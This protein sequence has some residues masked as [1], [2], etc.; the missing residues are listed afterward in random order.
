[1]TN[2]M[3]LAGDQPSSWPPKKT[4]QQL[5]IDHL[6][7][8]LDYLASQGSNCL[9]SKKYAENWRENIESLQECLYLARFQLPG[10]DI[11][12]SPNGEI[13]VRRTL[14]STN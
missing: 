2:F 5:V 14:S 4:T 10:L 8:E 12:F 6:E 7:K 9:H 13:S 1:M 11:S 3:P